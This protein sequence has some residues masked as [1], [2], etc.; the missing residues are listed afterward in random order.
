MKRVWAGLMA[1]LA[2]WAIAACGTSRELESGNNTPN[3]NSVEY[4]CPNGGIKYEPVATPFVVPS[5]PSG[6]VWTLLV[7]KAGN[8]ETSVE[9]ENETFPNPVVGQS[10][11]RSD[12]KGI[13]HAMTSA[14]M[15]PTPRSS[16]KG[17]RQP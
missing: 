14:A 7:L 6:K 13:S 16:Q 11:A 10:Y 4:W 17:A 2:V 9:V 15:A 12:G 1:V 8:E 5:P 3:T